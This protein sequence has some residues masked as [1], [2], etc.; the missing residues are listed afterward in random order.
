VDPLSHAYRQQCCAFEHTTPADTCTIVAKVG[1]KKQ[2]ISLI[3]KRAL[4]AQT[5]SKH[6]E[7]KRGGKKMKTQIGIN[8]TREGMGCSCEPAGQGKKGQ[9]VE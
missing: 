5:G 4:V 8:H 3:P 2:S 9:D 7:G 1:E 6:G